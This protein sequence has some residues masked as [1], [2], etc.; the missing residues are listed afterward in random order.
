MSMETLTHTVRFLFEKP[1]RLGSRLSIVWHAGEPLTVPVQFY[2]NA[3]RMLSEAAPSNVSVENCIQTNAMLVNQ[4]WCDLFQTWSVQVGVSLD[5]PQRI[6]DRNRVDRS[7]RGTFDRVIRGIEHLRRN[8]ID[9]S[10]IAVLCDES[11]DHPD[12]I[13]SFYRSLGVTSISFLAE[14]IQGVHLDSSL[15]NHT[16]CNRFRRFFEQIVR[17]RDVEPV[18]VSIREIDDYFDP[19]PVWHHAFRMAENV[20]LAV[21]NIAWDGSVSSF[22]PELLG[23]KN[24]QYGDFVFG[25]VRGSITDVI[26][27]AKFRLVYRDIAEGVEKCRNTCDYFAACGGGPPASK[28]SENGTFNSTETTSCRLRI[29]SL[30]DLAVAVAEKRRGIENRTEDSFRD[31]LAAL[32]PVLQEW[33]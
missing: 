22:S 4:E 28:L 19:R 8:N 6:H 9:V 3:F 25:N 7:G 31:R 13:W 18:E 15:R 21:L 16:E 32:A 30:G 1:E 26:N 17:L 20:P 29:K 11:L 27:S 23:M 24:L 5:G 14:E 12:E 2:E 10:V 33:R